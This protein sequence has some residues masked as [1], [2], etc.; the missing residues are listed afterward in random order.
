[1]KIFNNITNNFISTVFLLISC[2]LLI[3]TF[4]LFNIFFFLNF[5]SSDLTNIIVDNHIYDEVSSYLI[6]PFII[7][8]KNQFG[9]F[10]NGEKFFLKDLF[11]LV[12]NYLIFIFLDYKYLF[13]FKNVF[14][15]VGNIIFYYLLFSKLFKFSKIFSISSTFLIII[16]FSYTPFT[17]NYL[18]ELINLKSTQLMPLARSEPPGNT[19]IAFLISILFFFYYSKTKRYTLLIISLLTG[20]FSYFYTTLILVSF[21]NLITIKKLFEDKEN[22]NKKILDLFIINFFFFF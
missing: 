21:Y 19:N 3:I 1:M 12:Q 5:N 7:I 9:Y 16:T 8:Q 14:L 15:L 17:Y 13:V 2:I 20:F 10:S 22:K 4:N 18:F 6:R 11:S